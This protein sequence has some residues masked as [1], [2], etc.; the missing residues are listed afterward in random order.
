MVLWR[1][2][3]DDGRTWSDVDGSWEAAPRHGV[4]CVVVHDTTGTWGRFVNSGY[5]PRRADSHGNEYY[6]K[7]PDNEEPYPTWELAP[8]LN[9]METAFPG[10][11]AQIFIKYGRQVPQQLWQEIMQ[12]AAADEDFPK[13]S[14]RRRITD[15]PRN[16]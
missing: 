1:I 13:G 11:D 4:V 8:F 3:Y 10:L 15:Y 9:R 14:P 6:V 16:D 12:A 7:Y 5:A 2:Y